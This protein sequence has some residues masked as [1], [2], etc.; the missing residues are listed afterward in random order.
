MQSTVEKVKEIDLKISHLK[1]TYESILQI[2]TQVD[3]KKR[4]LET[5]IK[6]LEEE[7]IRAIEGQMDFDYL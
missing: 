1:S 3:R 7:R 6:I 4:S 2:H 5:D